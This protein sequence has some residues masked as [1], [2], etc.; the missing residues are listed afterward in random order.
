VILR[1][2]AIPLRFAIQAD[3]M[4]PEEHLSS[5]L[6]RRSD[7]RIQGVNHGRQQLEM[8]DKNLG[9]ILA[10]RG[11]GGES[12][13]Q[14]PLLAADEVHSRMIC[15]KSFWRTCKRL[16]FE[17]TE[18]FAD[19]RLFEN[20]TEVFVI[21]EEPVANGCQLIF[22]RHVRAGGNDHA[23]RADL[24]VVTGAGCFVETSVSPPRGD[25]RF[26]GALV[27]TE[28]RIAIDAEEGFFRGANVVGREVHHRVGHFADDG[29]HGFF[30]Q[31]FEVGFARREPVAVIM[32]SEIAQEG[33][34]F[35][36][37]IRRRSCGSCLGSAWHTFASVG[38]REMRCMHR[39]RDS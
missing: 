27:V 1:Q 8:F 17:F 9:E 19:G 10:L 13:T 25:V 23:F 26:V 12:S 6:Q 3:S 5:R 24:E 14:S 22:L 4:Q 21:V 39:G 11:A 30:Q 32:F 36:A 34:G 16:A 28:A 31:R 20:A 37:K 2:L 38:Q 33:N 18:G 15:G 35:R 7:R 29:E